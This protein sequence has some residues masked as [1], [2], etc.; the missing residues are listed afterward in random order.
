MLAI[1]QSHCNAWDYWTNMDQ[2]LTRLLH[3][4]MRLFNAHH[5]T[6]LSRAAVLLVCIAA[7]ALQSA[8]IAL[9]SHPDVYCRLVSSRKRMQPAATAA[10]LAA[11][12]VSADDDGDV[13][14]AS[15]QAALD[16]QAPTVV[17]TAVTV[18]LEVGS[19]G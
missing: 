8:K 9:P 11:V 5:S 4:I 19:R 2:V 10:E 17:G 3:H 14:A 6:L 16:K 13:D 12:A 1:R 15:A 18:L 7:G